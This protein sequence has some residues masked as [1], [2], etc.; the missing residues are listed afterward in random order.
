[1]AKKCDYIYMAGM[2][3]EA[4]NVLTE[5]D[6]P[7]GGRKLVRVTRSGGYDGSDGVVSLGVLRERF[8]TG[9][10][11]RAV[12]VT[13]EGRSVSGLPLDLA[14]CTGRK[15]R[16]NFSRVAKD[17]FDS[18]ESLAQLAREQLRTLPDGRG[19]EEAV[20]TR[21]HW[22]LRILP[23][24]HVGAV[25]ASGS[26]PLLTEWLSTVDLRTF[27][28]YRPGDAAV[29]H[30]TLVAARP[31]A[32]SPS[33]DLLDVLESSRRDWEPYAAASAARAV[34]REPELLDV[35]GPGVAL[36]EELA[37]VMVRLQR[38]RTDGYVSHGPQRLDVVDD[39][40]ALF[41]KGLRDGSAPEPETW[42]ERAQAAGVDASGRFCDDEHALVRAAAT[43]AAPIERVRRMLV[44]DADPVVVRAAAHRVAAEVGRPLLQE[45]R[46]G[47]GEVSTVP[48][49]VV[50]VDVDG[51]LVDGVAVRDSDSIVDLV[52]A[53]VRGVLVVA[54]TG[55][56]PAALALTGFRPDLAVCDGELIDPS[57]GV[58]L[59]K[60]SDK[61]E[62]VRKVLD[63]FGCRAPV[64]VGDGRVDVPMFEAVRAAGGRCGW[65]ASG[66]DDPASLA[67]DVIGPVG[68]GGVGRFVTDLL[69]GNP[70]P[71]VPPLRPVASVKKSVYVSQVLPKETFESL[72]T[73]DMLPA[74]WRAAH[75]HTTIA[76]PSKVPGERLPEPER[77]ASVEI[78]GKVA[79]G[80]VSAYAVRVGGLT[81][82]PN[83][84]PLHVTVGLAP[85]GNGFTAPVAAG[86]AVAQAIA[87]GTLELLER[88]IVVPAIASPAGSPEQRLPREVE[89]RAAVNGV[90][91]REAHRAVASGLGDLVGEVRPLQ[92][93]VE[94]GRLPERGLVVLVGPPASGK[95]TAAERIVSTSSNAVVVSLDGIRGEVNGDDASQSRLGD[96]VG[97]A[98]A[99]MRAELALGRLV[100]S[101]A[102]NLE[103]RVLRGHVAR[104]HALG[105]PVVVL[106]ADVS[107]DETEARDLR[108]HGEGERSVGGSSAPDGAWD[109]V[110]AGKVFTKMYDRWD[111]VSGPL[112]RGDFGADAV[113][114][115]ALVDRLE[116]VPGAAC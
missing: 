104:A 2:R 107:R 15:G 31:P 58:S 24:G 8:G 25:A 103:E 98:E 47:G 86:P 42:S 28:T 30:R 82:Q 57:A 110:K 115:L 13:A 106:Y 78:Y 84:T 87:D 55:R 60:V 22:V 38:L 85:K 12:V 80:E 83:G 18:P 66:Q 97:L 5:I 3:F 26:S 63:V 81:H 88:P 14:K 67:T 73:G 116:E 112:L 27:V 99:R 114:P 70:R 37:P 64:A 20:A 7:R 62:A 9:A 113:A 45:G 40:A 29:L 93:A 61:G 4:A 46:V 111:D 16:R 44:E 51:T 1:M 91:L 79:T 53:Q 102:T 109:A 23:D 54:V 94:S 89:V 34:R 76:F 43:H 41:E 72:C 48:P 77:G 10:V 6:L 52:E 36:L 96:V 108:R 33:R 21:L 68:S 65:V 105:L 100:V 101:D 90:D 59:G 50:F 39:R 49:D 35:S 32:G 17:G 75:G 56:S 71:S 92:T 11:L 95:S 69:N 19:D 74:G